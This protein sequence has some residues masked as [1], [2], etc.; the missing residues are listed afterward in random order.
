MP[1]LRR[2]CLVGFLGARLGGGDVVVR[3]Q[4][5][6]WAEL[7]PVR[8]GKGAGSVLDNGVVCLGSCV[9]EKG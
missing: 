6:V 3:G 2:C 8:E 9:G 7:V 4:V 5:Y 1:G